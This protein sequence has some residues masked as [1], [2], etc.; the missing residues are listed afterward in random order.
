MSS[1]EERLARDISAITGGVVVTESDLVNA[2]ETLEDRIRVK[3]RR[4]RGR[5][6]AVIAAAAVVIP[7]LGVAAYQT[8]DGSESAPPV[9]SVPTSPSGYDAFLKGSAPTPDLLE[10]AWR[11]DNGYVLVRFAAPNVVSFDDTGRLFGSPGVQGTYEIAGDVITVSV[12]SGLAG[13]AGQTFDMRAS[14][15]KPGAMRFVLPTAGLS[16]C[17][18]VAGRGDMEKLLPTSN[19]VA[20][21]DITTDTTKADWSPP[22]N[23]AALHGDWM[24]EGGGYLMEINPSGS[25]YVA[26]ESGEPIDDGQWSL[27][28]TDLTLTS[29]AT[30][31]DCAGGDRLVW[32]DLGQ[33]I[34]GT[35]GMRGTSVQNTCGGAWASKVW[36]LLPDLGS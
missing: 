13:C 29:S 14:L 28:G 35:T 25:Y 30:S 7:I 24:A 3:R 16:S 4:D 1:I 27:R 33:F 22:V 31:R 20:E 10:G 26:D 19:S 2:R 12:D 9:N 36:F 23:A 18:S 17:M 8:L 15:P 5:T 21:F 32:G 11:V 6:L 34:T